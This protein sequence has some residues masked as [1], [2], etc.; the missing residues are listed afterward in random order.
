MIPAAT[1][2][3]GAFGAYEKNKT[4]ERNYQRD[5]KHNEDSA[6]MRYIMDFGQKDAQPAGNQTNAMLGGALGGFTQGA[7]IAQGLG[8]DGWL[9][10][11]EDAAKLDELKG[12]GAPTA[13]GGHKGGTFSGQSAEKTLFTPT[14]MNYGMEPTFAETDAAIRTLEQ[15]KAGNTLNDPWLAS[16]AKQMSQQ[17]GPVAKYPT[18]GPDPRQNYWNSRTVNEINVNPYNITTANGL[19]PPGYPQIRSEL[20]P[21]MYN[22]YQRAGY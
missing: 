10:G 11:D 8:K 21:P 12:S 18:S 20:Q 9:L 17:I 15:Q 4:D 5:M 1:A 6:R 16:D 2:A 22:P 3:L 13:I 14:A 7:A 19:T